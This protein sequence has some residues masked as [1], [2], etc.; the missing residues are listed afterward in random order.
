MEIVN[1]PRK[2]QY[3]LSGDVLC[4]IYSYCNVT[5][6]VT[7]VAEKAQA[8]WLKYDVVCGIILSDHGTVIV[9]TTGDE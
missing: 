1:N 7:S 3:Q 4:I 5:R 9:S 2:D 6:R 8:E